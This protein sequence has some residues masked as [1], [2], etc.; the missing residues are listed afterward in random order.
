MIRGRNIILRK[1]VLEDLAEIYEHR[2]HFNEIGAFISPDLPSLEIMK[3][4]FNEKGYWESFDAAPF[5]ITDFEGEI[6]GEIIYFTGAPYIEG[7]EIGY[8]IFRESERGR[9]Y[10]TEA[11]SIL[12]S[13]LFELEPVPR[14]QINVISLN[15][16]KYQGC[17]KVRISA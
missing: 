12:S 2:S 13:Y 10:M 17:R 15:L 3:K 7:Y 11:L 16:G 14:L 8:Q 9:G 6:L 5:L 1:P 4:N